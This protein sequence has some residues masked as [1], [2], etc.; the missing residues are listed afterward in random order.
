MTSFLMPVCLGLNGFR[1]GTK[2]DRLV[3]AAEM[4]A[5]AEEGV[6]APAPGRAGNENPS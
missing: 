5:A 3:N 6:G 1:N 4:K 2:V